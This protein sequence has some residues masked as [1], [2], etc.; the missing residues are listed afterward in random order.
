MLKSCPN[1]TILATSREALGCP[2]EKSYS[3]SPLTLPE[4]ID[5][6]NRVRVAASEA[7]QLFVVSVEQLRGRVDNRFKL[8]TA[9]DPTSATRHQT[10]L[11]AIQWSYD[12]LTQEEQ[13]LFR[14]LSVFVGG[15]SLEAATGVC[16][17]SQDEF[18]LLDLLTHLADKSLIVVDRPTRSSIRY[19]MLESIRQFSG[20]QLE[21]HNES[22]ITRDQHADY[23][24]DLAE[25]A[26]SDRTAGNWDLWSPPLEREYENLLAAIQWLRGSK[27]N[28]NRIQ[29][30]VGAMWPFWYRRGYVAFGNEIVSEI[31]EKYSSDEP[32]ETRIRLLSGAGLLSLYHGEYAQARNR[33]ER[34]L[35]ISEALGLPDGVA[36]ALNGLGAVAGAQEDYT[37]SRSYY[38]RCLEVCSKH[39]GLRWEGS[40]L[41]NLGEVAIWQGDYK[42]ALSSY[43]KAVAVR[44]EQGDY[45]GV[46]Y[47]LSGRAYACVRLGKLEE[48]RSYLGETFELISQHGFQLIAVEALN[49][50][51]ELAAALR[52]HDMAVRIG[53]AL[54]AKQKRRV[55][56]VQ[57]QARTALGTEQFEQEWVIGQAMSFDETMGLVVEWIGRD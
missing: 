33:Y 4:R 20:D 45:P 11:A 17:E 41:A 29:R 8:L 25:M 22:R 15:W 36:Q 24:T 49:A 57:D 51:Q 7:V 52:E 19:R 40:A 26:E 1:L 10:L 34:C 35:D 13:K 21:T 53:G 5:Q 23:F 2:G 37:S 9:A 54:P 31:V 46:A 28:R 18:A 48:A 42:A 47:T 16:G 32:T 38:E 30:L 50:A 43:A 55:L 6:P 39:G 3:I 27:E 12:L 14:A 56:E 44:R